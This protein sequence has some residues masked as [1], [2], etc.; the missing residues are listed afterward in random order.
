[1]KRRINLFGGPGVGKSTLAAHIFTSLK[2]AG[3]D[4][5][6][7]QERFKRNVY[8]NRIIH[9]WDYVH[10]FAKQFDA[11]HHI[12]QA[13]VQRLVTD[14][15]L[16]LQCVYAQHAGCP[17]HHNLRSISRRFDEDYP[18]HNVLVYRLDGDYQESGRFEDAKQ[19]REMHRLI[20]ETLNGQDVAY[21][22]I[23]PRRHCD[24]NYLFRL[25]E[26]P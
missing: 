17:A 23:N 12:L 15:P 11:E 7:V 26:I 8:E 24:I 6:L 2:K 25:L 14:S 3:A 1:M 4:I 20:E 13:G 19:A 5:E 10:S 18:A 9:P 16:L 22:S 21:T